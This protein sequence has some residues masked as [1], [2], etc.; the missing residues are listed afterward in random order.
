MVI[1]YGICRKWSFLDQQTSSHHNG[2]KMKTPFLAEEHFNK[3]K[4]LLPI[5]RRPRKYDAIKILSGIIFVIKNGIPWRHLPKKYGK[6][7]T[8]YTIF[9]RWSAK[10]IFDIIFEKLNV[11]PGDKNITMIDS[12]V[13]K[14]HRTAASLKADKEPRAIGR[15]RGGLTTKIH[16]LCT[17]D[18]R[19]LDFVLSDGQAGDAKFASDFIIKNSSVMKD[20]LADKAYD[21]NKIRTIL[22][23]NNIGVCIPPKKNRKEDI[24]YDKELYKKRHVVENM[25]GRIKDWRG[26]AM[27][28]CRCAH[29]YK[30]FVCIALI[31][32]FLM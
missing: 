1:W 29:T 14:V 20:F 24:P 11:T 26:I 25:F 16:L 22:S 4:H 17:A 30:S 8:I 15:S 32:L 28:Y 19:P 10:G 6:W 23:Q 5:P 2:D 13:T 27:R 3:I 31:I 9:H 7:S 12:T 18:R 21:S